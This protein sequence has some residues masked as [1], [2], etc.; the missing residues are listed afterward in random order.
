[1]AD[2]FR[3]EVNGSLWMVHWIIRL[4]RLKADH[5]HQ[6]DQCVT[7]KYRK[8]CR[9]QTT[10]HAFESLS[11]YFD[12]I[13]RSICAACF[14][15]RAPIMGYERF[16]FWFWESPTTG[17]YA[18]KVKKHFHFLI[19]CIYFLPYLLNDSQTIRSTIHFSKPLLYVMLICSDWL[20]SF[21]A[22]FMSF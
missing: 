5:H 10:L 21:K 22:V 14:K 13:Q 4:V 20:I 16:I 18:C 12:V 11:L 19:I 6:I 8:S 1:M 2:S 7:S 9:Q 17:W 3:S 15:S